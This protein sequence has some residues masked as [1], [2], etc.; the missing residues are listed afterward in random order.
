MKK[1]FK[2][3]NIILKLAITLVVLFIFVFLF[4]FGLS[5]FKLS[6]DMML[7]IISFLGIITI[8]LQLFIIWKWLIWFE[9]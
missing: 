5:Q 7:S 2:V 9:K 8:P 4:L 3:L 1:L 6:N